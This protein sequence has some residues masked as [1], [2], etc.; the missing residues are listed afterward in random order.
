MPLPARHIFLILAACAVTGLAATVLLPALSGYLTFDDH[1]HLGRIAALVA[2]RTP[3]ALWEALWTDTGPTGR[4]LAGLTFAV[5][6]AL[7]HSVATLKWV[8]L[9]LHLGVAFLLWALAES[10][11]VAAGARKVDARTVATMATTLW[12]LHP[13]HVSTVAYAVQRMTL[14][15]SLFTVAAVLVWVHARTRSGTV[16]VSAL[17]AIAAL[18]ILGMLAKESAALLPLYILMVEAT[19]VKDQRGSRRVYVLL[20]AAASVA[21]LALAWWVGWSGYAG[22]PWTAVERLLTEARALWWYAGQ[23]LLPR[24]DELAL[25]HDD[26]SVSRGMLEPPTTMLA[27][28]GLTAMLVAAYALRR[29]LPVVSFGA[30]WFLAGHALESTLLPLELVFEHR[31]YL[32]SFGL[33]LAAVW[34]LRAVLRRV[35]HSRP[36][37][38]FAV[39]YVAAILATAGLTYTRAQRWGDDPRPRLEHLESRGASMRSL[40]E[41]A[42]TWAAGVPGV[43]VS[44]AEQ[45]A[46]GLYRR[47]AEIADGAEPLFGWVAMET[48][49]GRRPR[50]LLDELTRRLASAAPSGTTINGI[51]MLT[52][53]VIE[54]RCP[55][56]TPADLERIYA[57]ALD[58]P[59]MTAWARARVLRDRAASRW[60]LGDRQGALGDLA[61]ARRLA[62]DDVDT[63]LDQARLLAYGGDASRALAA[64]REAERRDRLGRRTATIAGLRALVIGLTHIEPERAP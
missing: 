31:N 18:W 12:L 21:V 22:R 44:E 57:A 9:A 61:A 45:R 17:A 25:Y 3:A 53:C 4:P 60:Y 48:S 29:R 20:L 6:A 7:G 35:L 36:R 39:V 56:L 54:R 26:F 46:K 27:I 49:R 8:N 40:V 2:Q 58:N 28:A 1:A 43:P 24:L 33:L 30:L 41:A 63:I 11:V 10:V 38:V 50:K 15:A 5:Q 51:H 16:S 64:L 59:R 52:Q 34:M 14:L 13:L 42:A 55:E 47:A 62:P 19:V 23:T 32:P 37:F